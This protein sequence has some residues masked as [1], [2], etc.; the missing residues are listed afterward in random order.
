VLVLPPSEN[1]HEKKQRYM[2]ITRFRLDPRHNSQELESAF[3]SGGKQK[4]CAEDTIRTI[5]NSRSYSIEKLIYSVWHRNIDSGKGMG[6]EPWRSLNPFCKQKVS[7]FPEIMAFIPVLR[8][9]TTMRRQQ[10]S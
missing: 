6:T 5:K 4:M 2:P 8:A 9:K 1:K 10:C 3:C 7:E